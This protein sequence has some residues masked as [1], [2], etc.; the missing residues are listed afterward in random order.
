[1]TFRYHAA[2]ATSKTRTVHGTTAPVFAAS[3]DACIEGEIVRLDDGSFAY[4]ADYGGS[5]A[6]WRKAVCVDAGGNVY[7][8]RVAPASLHGLLA[9]WAINVERSFD[10]LVGWIE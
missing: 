4:V 9:G 3:L 5:F 7:R 8:E 2:R 1:M 10:D 6:L